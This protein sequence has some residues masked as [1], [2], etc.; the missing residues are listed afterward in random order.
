MMNR[1]SSLA[2]SFTKYMIS[3]GKS[4]STTTIFDKILAKTIPSTPVYED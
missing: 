1:L 3:Q 2:G 4:P